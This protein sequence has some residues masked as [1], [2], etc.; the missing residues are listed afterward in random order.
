MGY[1]N[2]TLACILENHRMLITEHIFRD[3]KVNNFEAGESL[4]FT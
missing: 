3:Y 4:I 1:V 2:V